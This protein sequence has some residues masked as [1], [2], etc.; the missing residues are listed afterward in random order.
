MINPLLT[1]EIVAPSTWAG[2]VACHLQL[3]RRQKR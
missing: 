2:D 1:R 3:R